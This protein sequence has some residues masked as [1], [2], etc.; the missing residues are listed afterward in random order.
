[1]AANAAPIGR[2]LGRMMSPSSGR[3]I[4]TYSIIAVCVV[5]FILEVV[6]GINPIT[7]AGRSVV[8]NV[9]AYHPHDIIHSPWTI[10][11]VNFVHAEVLHIASNMVSL[12][13]VGVPLER[14]LG[15]TRFLAL[16][17]VTGIGAVVG[18]DFFA[19]EEVVGASGAIFGVLGALVVFARR[20]GLRIAQ[21]YV[22]IV[23]NL[24]IGYFVPQIAWQA[25]VGGL[26]VGL[27]LGFLLLKTP[28][29][30][31]RSVQIASFVG[32]TVLL[33]AALLVNALA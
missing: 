32:V 27:G 1:M 2:R 28:G 20:M 23:L 31:R 9:L 25:H 4:A 19:H 5:V 30:R 21:L 15:R 14:Y 17:F 33:L 24:A 13:F 3:P 11:T 8:E 12:Y 22:V 29:I 7:G 6:T 16:F 10:I 18:V 26:I